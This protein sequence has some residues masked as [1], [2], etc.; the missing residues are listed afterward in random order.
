MIITI[1][2]AGGKKNED[3]DDVDDVETKGNVT[4]ENSL[5]KLRNSFI[6][7]NGLETFL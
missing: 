1:L 5:F 6:E 7:E 3:D 4:L 2:V